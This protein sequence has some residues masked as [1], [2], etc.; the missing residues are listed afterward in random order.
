MDNNAYDGDDIPLSN[1]R[2]SMWMVDPTGGR[3]LQPEMRKAERD[4]LAT[5]TYILAVAK[6]A[7]SRIFNRGPTSKASKEPP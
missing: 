3:I 6:K 2:S 4:L 7:S 5:P 1:S